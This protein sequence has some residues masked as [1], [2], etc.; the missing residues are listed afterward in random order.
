M[1]VLHPAEECITKGC[2]QQK[3]D[4]RRR[5]VDW[6]RY[7]FVVL[8]L[9]AALA[10][11]G[12]A[13]AAVIAPDLQMIPDGREKELTSE[14]EDADNWHKF[15]LKG[16][17]TLTLGL[18][19]FEGADLDLCL[20]R[21]APVHMDDRPSCFTED[22]PSLLAKSVRG[23]Y[24]RAG[25]RR[26]RGG[27]V[28]DYS[29]MGF[30]G[31]SLHR[32]ELEEPGDYYIRVH[33]HAQRVLQ[34]VEY[35]LSYELAATV[36]EV[37]I[38]NAVTA[39][40]RMEVREGDPGSYR[41]RLSR[42]PEVETTVG[43][44][45]HAGTDLVVQSTPTFSPGDGQ[46]RAGDWGQ[47]KV[48]TVR[49]R[50]DGD[51][52]QDGT[53]RLCHTLRLG[54]GNG[55]VVP[56]GCMDVTIV[57]DDEDKRGVT[58]NPWPDLEVREGGTAE[59]TVVL[60]TQPAGDVTVTL[61]ETALEGTDLTVDQPVLAFTEDNWNRPQ[62]VKV[63]AAEDEDTM[64]DPPVDLNFVVTGA[65]YDGLQVDDLEITIV[66]DDIPGVV[67]DA[68]RDGVMVEEGGQA[69]YRVWLDEAPHG[70]V[71][72][73][74]AWPR[75]TDLLISPDNLTFGPNNWDQADA[76]PVTLT[77]R[78]DG[79]AVAD[80]PVTIQHSVDGA[81]SEQV[82][83][84]ILENDEAGVTVNRREVPVEEGGNEEY[85][86]VLDTKPTGYVVVRMTA[87]LAGTDLTV[88]PM[89]LTFTTANWDMAQPVTV[90]AA[91]DEDVVQD[92]MVTLEYTVTGADPQY[93]GL[94]VDPVEVEIR[95]VD[96]VTP[97]EDRLVKR[98]LKRAV[99]GAVANVTKNIG[100]R[101][102]SASGGQTTLTLAGQR[103]PIG[104]VSAAS[105]G[106]GTVWKPH[107]FTEEFTEDSLGGRARSLSGVE[108]FRSTEFQVALGATELQPIDFSNWTLWGRGDI[109]LF[110][111]EGSDEGRYDTDLKAGYLG[112]DK[113][114]NQRWLG[115]VAT[116][117]I[118]VD[119]EYGLDSGGGGRL[120]FTMTSVHPYL[121]YS[122]DA[123]NE[124]WVILGAGTGDIENQREVLLEPESSRV[125]L[126]M[127]ATGLR[128]VLTT[129][130][131][132]A[133]LALVGDLGFGYLDGQSDTDD[134]TIDNLALETLRLR[135]GLSGSYTFELSE[136]QTA[137]SFIEVA[138][139]FDG[140]EGDSDFGLE[141]SGGVV[142]A[143]PPS[144]LALELR[145]NI[146]GLYTDRFYREYGA[147]ATVSMT[148]QAGGEGLSLAVTP[149]IGQ[150]TQG[151]DILWRDAP[152]AL[153]EGSSDL[154]AM[155]LDT[156]VGYGFSAP[157]LMGGSRVLLTPFGE[158]RLKSEDE[159]RLR[160]GVRF[161]GTGSADG[162][163]HVEFFVD[164]DDDSGDVQHRVGLVGRWRF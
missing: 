68:P 100:A 99:A 6:S 41:V 130:G 92:P 76:K 65:D 139:R 135:L 78:E 108:L 34:R 91:E 125:L 109:A 38:A 36:L 55:N 132:V 18:E 3:A 66:E 52:V 16:Q 159:R 103:V 11:A 56:A 131:T 27:D 88:E 141:F 64:K 143:H 44:T 119:S 15:T 14:I 149:R 155:S 26:K 133:D 79:D 145:G 112:V 43:V 160:A 147:S 154:S 120:K 158:M 5:C 150:Q 75:G 60:N 62:S 104:G 83:V 13:N 54:S 118:R 10:A 21:G 7:A 32:I 28:Y 121:R 156:R 106:V 37:E 157:A 17:Q 116:S 95:E 49:A 42:N 137:T 2:A 50:H 59:Y 70:E 144:G 20:Y 80:D 122:P 9:A 113:W 140:G 25:T 8:I 84:T 29:N 51:A 123:S 47:W 4:A 22:V 96:H 71:S 93:T 134:Q 45:G 94:Q 1:M 81:D 129:W 69:H 164:Q 110:D 35:V 12:L 97:A 98:S 114:L 86:V 24:T 48:V 89:A 85:T 105:A 163:S 30:Y 142:F 73:V 57:E 107:L 53:I 39:G 102:S 40:P 146:L 127:G 87:D 90:T 33:W 152:F 72:V 82:T 115:G 117:R 124:W 161:G 74:L 162:G 138:G 153:A 63:Q 77:A 111:S 23:G 151:A 19:R 148:S 31:E 136:Q 61:D 67:V 128:R 46:D 58:V 101:F 126:Y